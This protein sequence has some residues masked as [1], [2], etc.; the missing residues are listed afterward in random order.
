[1]SENR[2]Y[3]YALFHPEN[4]LPCYIGKGNGDR[5]NDHEK[6]PYKCSNPH[7]RNLINRYRELPKVKISENLPEREAFKLEIALIKILGREKDGGILY[8]LTKGGD[9]V[10]GWKHGE[11]S[12]LKMSEGRLGKPSWNKGKPASEETKKNMSRAATGRKRSEE[13]K[14]KVSEKLKGQRKGVPHSQAHIDA[15]CKAWVTRKK[16]HTIS[17]ETKRRISE[18]SILYNESNYVA[19]YAQRNQT[20]VSMYE[21]G[22]SMIEIGK[23]FNMSRDGSGWYT[24]RD[25]KSGK[26]CTET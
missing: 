26:R 24:K 17:D 22:T 7:L 16:I 13:T 8:N 15:L 10:S 12:L 5:W 18:K 6:K 19:N 11:E 14:R 23:I 21:D 3:V 2:Y 9:G 25:D 20:W 4:G 1:M